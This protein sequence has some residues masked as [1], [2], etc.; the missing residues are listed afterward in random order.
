MELSQILSNKLWLE[1]E[2]QWVILNYLW[3]FS[4]GV[5]FLEWTCSILKADAASW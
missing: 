2:K 1:G 4:F 5:E 3:G